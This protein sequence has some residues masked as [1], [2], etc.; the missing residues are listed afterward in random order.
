MGKKIWNIVLVP[1]GGGSVR[2]LRIPVRLLYAAAAVLALGGLVV[3]GSV[4]LHL[5]NLHNIRSMTA[6]KQENA[7]LRS[8]LVSVNSAL[9]QVEAM[10]QDGERMERQAR[11]L[12]GMNPVS[13]PAEAAG[14]GGPLVSVNPAPPAGA[15]GVESEL[16]AQDARLDQLRR[17]VTSQQSN[18]QKTLES[19]R[20][21]GDRLA[22]TP[23]IC[24]LRSQ[25]VLSSGFGY[26]NDPFTNQKAFHGGLDLRASSGTLVYAP[27]AGKVSFVGWDGEFG[28]CVKIRHGYGIETGFCHLSSAKVEVG[29]EVSRG[30][31]LGAVGSSGRSTAPHLH[32]E[33]SVDGALRDP[34]VYIV[35]SHSFTD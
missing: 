28:L 16:Q 32:Y 17:R 13:D 26:R 21:L 9:S 25:Y 27:A 24:P 20:G 31:C 33:L 3:I 7:S 6:L 1:E 18:F 23:S 14:T 2:N 34:S 10:V 15:T 30:D 11:L 12:A 19:L 5:W 29:Q 35:N 8:H 4:G 22:H